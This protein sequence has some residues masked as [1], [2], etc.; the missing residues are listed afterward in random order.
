MEARIVS[1]G[2]DLR[3]VGVRICTRPICLA[4]VDRD[5]S[6]LQYVP[7]KFKDDP[8]M[9][10]TAVT[11]NGMAL[12]YVPNK[13][14]EICL[15]AIEQIKAAR[16][17]VPD[18]IKARIN[19]RAKLKLATNPNADNPNVINQ[20]P[21]TVRHFPENPSDVTGDIISFLGGRSRKRR[22]SRKPTRR[23]R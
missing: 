5:G 23:Y 1:G 8:E 2:S 3:W 16:H 17:F 13:T 21:E 12:K 18:E 9:C 7:N 4:A 14:L 10:F 19:D 11:S 6:A 20:L 22:K 15:V